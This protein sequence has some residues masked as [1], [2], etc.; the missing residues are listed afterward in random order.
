MMCLSRVSLRSVFCCLVLGLACLVGAMTSFAQCAAGPQMLAGWDFSNVPGGP[1]NFGEDDFFPTSPNIDTEDRCAFVSG[2]KRHWS[3]STSGSGARFAWGGNGFSAAAID[4][5]SA[6]AAGNYVTFFVRSVPGI[7]ISLTSIEPYNIRRSGTGPTTGQ[8]Q[9]STDGASFADIGV[10]IAWGNT[11]TNSGNPQSTI[12]LSG[13]PSMANLNGA[14]EITF[15]LVLWGATSSGGTWYLNDNDSTSST[16][17][18]D[19]D[20]SIN[21]SVVLAPTAADAVVAGQ[22]VDGF[23]SG[24]SGAVVTLMS[25]TGERRTVITSSFG[26][27][28]FSAVETGETYV[29]AASSKRHRFQPRSVTVA[30][31]ID[32]LRITALP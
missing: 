23:G 30:D 5:A 6:I 26:Y 28:R 11:T 8:W 25:P 10:P 1:G 7:T 14:A 4:R 27:F 18:P 32:D 3:L 31:N 12:T 2:L 19:I 9:F 22:V 29:V 15:R 21:G 24:I 16:P 13:I 20:F 17:D